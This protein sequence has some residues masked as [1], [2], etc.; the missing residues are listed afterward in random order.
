MQYEISYDE[1]VLLVMY[2]LNTGLL[3]VG[4]EKYGNVA[5]LKSD[6]VQHL[7][8]VCQLLLFSLA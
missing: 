3:G 6:A 8:D 1:S 2:H 5:A 7:F 4:F